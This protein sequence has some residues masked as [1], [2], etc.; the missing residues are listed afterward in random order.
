MRNSGWE[1]FILLTLYYSIG[2]KCALAIEGVKCTATNEKEAKTFS[3]DEC[4]WSFDK[5]Q[6][7]SSQENVYESIGTELLKHALDGYNC[8]LMGEDVLKNLPTNSV[9]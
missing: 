4:F 1:I 5:S 9:S 3:F 7:F 6:E 8:C 2:A